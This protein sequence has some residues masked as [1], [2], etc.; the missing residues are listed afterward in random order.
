MSSFFRA[1][2]DFSFSEY[3]TTKII[4]ILYVISIVLAGLTWVGT[5]LYMLFGLSRTGLGAIAVIGG[6]IFCPI[7]FILHVVIIRMTYEILIVVFGIAENVRDMTWALTGGR[8]APTANPPQPQYP[9][10]GQYQYPPQQ[11]QYQQPP[12]QPPQQQY[13]QAGQYQYPPQQPGGPQYPQP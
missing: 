5:L 1:L 9:Q 2:F 4:K 11:P 13:P 8:K 6:L 10:P 12:Q 7:G 3:V